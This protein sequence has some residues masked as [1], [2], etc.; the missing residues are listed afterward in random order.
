MVRRCSISSPQP[1][2]TQK[3]DNQTSVAVCP[4]RGPPYFNLPSVG[5]DTYGRTG[6]GYPAGRL[7][8]EDWVYG[9]VE[10]RFDLMRNRLLGAVAFVNGSTLS[11]ASGNYGRWAYGGGAGVR[12]RLDKKYGTNLAI[13]FAW[14]RDGSR[15]VWFWL[16]EAL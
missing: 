16:N 1:W 10:Y 4:G 12:V 8:G 9:D 6:R 14:G 2:E 11:D 13:D 5:W 3:K 15:G 7:R